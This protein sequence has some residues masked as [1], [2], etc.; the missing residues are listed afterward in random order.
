LR[1]KA[2]KYDFLDPPFCDPRIVLRSPPIQGAFLRGLDSAP[3]TL[4][5]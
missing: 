5:G 1:C 3:M 2:N 4:D